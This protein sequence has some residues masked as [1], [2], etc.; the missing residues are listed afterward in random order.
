MPEDL[1]E[2]GFVPPLEI[3][4][5]VYG[6]DGVADDDPAELFH[7]TSKFYPSFAPRQAPGIVLMQD[8]SVQEA[9]G[10]GHRRRGHEPPL[11][12][13]APTLPPVP[14]GD[15]IGHRR[16]RYEFD[17]RPL[18]LV[19]LSS[20][21]FYGYGVTAPGLRAAPSGGALYPL[22]IYAA[23]NA[24]DGL[25]PGLYQYDPFEAG[26]RPLRRDSLRDEISEMIL[27]PELVRNA[28]LVLLLSCVFW[29]TRFKYGLRGYRF[30]LL[31]AGHVAQNMLLA[32]EAMG[33]GAAPIGGFYDRK[34]DEML[35]LDGVNE[36]TLYFLAFAN[37]PDD[38]I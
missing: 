18:D 38:S 28:S 26:L 23:V 2:A 1:R 29:R 9:I 12:L 5:S 6:E 36:S 13:P 19:Q 20:L 31:E 27:N 16:T 35:E 15:V 33:L 17:E 14:I 37:R 11:A 3:P 21:L 25:E 10:R 24:V 30:A 4:A 32:A 8:E 34:I 7:E 22:E